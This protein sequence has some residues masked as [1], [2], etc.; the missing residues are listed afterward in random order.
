MGVPRNKPWVKHPT[1]PAPG[2]NIS[3]IKDWGGNPMFNDLV[4]ACR[5]PIKQDYTTFDGTL[6][7][8]TGMVTDLGTAT[9]V[10]LVCVSDGSPRLSERYVLTWT[11]TGTCTL[12]ATG[13]NS[14]AVVGTPTSNRA[15]YDITFG[16]T[17]SGIIYIEH[18]S[19]SLT[20]IELVPE[21]DEGISGPGEASEFYAPYV[22]LH[23]SRY[24]GGI[25]FMTALQTNDQ[26]TATYIGQGANPEPV[27]G[28]WANRITDDLYAFG[29]AAETWNDA[30][31]TREGGMSY[32]SCIRF[33]QAC[34]ANP[35]IT[36]PVAATDDYATQFANLMLEVMPPRMQLELE[37][38]NELWNSGFQ[39]YHFCHEQGLVEEA[40]NP[41]RLHNASFPAVSWGL[42]RSYQIFEIV[43]DIFVAA[44]RGEDLVRI[45]GMQSEQGVTFGY[46]PMLNT[47]GDASPRTDSGDPA[48]TPVYEGFDVVAT[49]SYTNGGLWGETQWSNNGAL[50]DAGVK[51][52]YTQNTKNMSNAQLLAAR[53]VEVDASVANWKLA[54]TYFHSLTNADGNALEAWIYEGHN[55][56][57]YAVGAGPTVDTT[58]HAQ[59]AFLHA[60]DA[61]AEGSIAY[62]IQESYDE[63]GFDKGYLFHSMG[64][65]DNDIGD[66][67]AH[68]DFDGPNTRGRRIDFALGGGRE[69]M[70]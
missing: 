20:S 30:G 53:I 35:W 31:L 59:I 62:G 17:S 51:H 23:K 58:L 8:T 69:Y 47:D 26:H 7:A 64:R 16:T 5:I 1:N 45:V 42:Y 15:V 25:R 38:G 18:S 40:A 2:A 70:A 50:D 52:T 41:G 55:A 3:Y 21:A 37:L 22:A 36:L 27:S 6:D 66:W 14:V 24:R 60:S 13:A 46:T 34:D 33:A 68:V 57:D 39:Q 12:A 67:V 10:L 11:G 44:G 61:D 32:E 56:H 65:E 19:T 48:V 28:I 4:R 43:K 9:S 63:S 49:G 54:N 29:Q